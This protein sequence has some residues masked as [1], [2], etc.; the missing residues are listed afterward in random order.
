M[1]Q[2]FLDSAN[3]QEIEEALGWGVLSGLTTNPSLMSKEEEPFEFLVKKICSLMGENPVSVEVLDTKAEGMVE[4]ARHLA[5]QAP[6]VVI[7]IP[8]GVEGLKAVSRLNRKEEKIPCNVTLVFSV[9]QAL[10]AAHAGAAY[11]SP[12]IGRLDDIGWDGVAL[13]KEIVEVFS[14]QK[15]TETKIIA[16]SIRHPR[17]VHEVAAAGAHIATVPFRVLKQMAGH[18]LTDMGLERFLSDWGRARQEEGIRP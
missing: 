7:K 1:S 16:A 2:I 4:E 8:M 9:N 17:H 15:I 6:N 18:P 3:L 5:A 13:V 11:V 10:L 14:R 12:F